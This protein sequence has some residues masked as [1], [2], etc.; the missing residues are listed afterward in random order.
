MNID[1]TYVDTHVSTRYQN[2]VLINENG[3]VQ[4]LWLMCLGEHSDD[5]TEL[6]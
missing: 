6:Q 2:K 1:A 5:D 4:A 3:I